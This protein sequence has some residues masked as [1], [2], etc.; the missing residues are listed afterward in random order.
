M[1][2]YLANLQNMDLK[3]HKSAKYK[4]KLRDKINKS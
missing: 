2:K 1:T 3:T 4:I